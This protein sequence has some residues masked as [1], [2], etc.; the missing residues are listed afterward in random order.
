M[1][2]YVSA[3]EN[4]NLVVDDRYIGKYLN[5]IVRN[6]ANY[7]YNNAPLMND[8]PRADYFVEN[9]CEDS[10]VEKCKYLLKDAIMDAIDRQ[11]RSY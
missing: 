6:I 7:A 5:Q 8:D 4:Y 11:L 9:I 2:R 3:D 1:K 10:E